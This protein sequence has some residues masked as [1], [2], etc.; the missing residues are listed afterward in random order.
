MLELSSVAHMAVHVY[1]HGSLHTPRQPVCLLLRVDTAV[2][3]LTATKYTREVG[4]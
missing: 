3:F 2:L 1:A 4:S